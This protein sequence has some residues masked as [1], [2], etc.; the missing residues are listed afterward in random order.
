MRIDQG[1]EGIVADGAARSLVGRFG[2]PVR[3]GLRK[4]VVIEA[5]DVRAGPKANGFAH[6]AQRKGTF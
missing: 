2:V 1:V 4:G 5:A 3:K 6:S